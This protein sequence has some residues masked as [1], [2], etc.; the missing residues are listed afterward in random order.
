VLDINRLR[1]FRSVVAAGSIQA[2]ATSLGYTPSAVSQQVAA[3]QRET[4]LELVSRVG[5]GI[6]PT[7]AG[8][9][10]AAAADGV[11]TQLGEVETVVA[12]LRAGRSGALSVSYFASVGAAWMP[13]LV[14]ALVAGFPQLRLD[15]MICEDL[16]PEP[17]ADIQIIVERPGFTPAAGRQARH[18]LED[19]YVAVLPVGHSLVGAGA[20][21]LARLA[22]ERWIDND[23]TDGWCRR[24]LLQTCHAAGFSPV[25]QV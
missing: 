18:L 2:A 12:D 21:E 8:L 20:I 10:L 11:L 17:G 5:R 9:R 23:A 22:G 7:P 13:Q 1:V 24:N 25:F 6:R 4:G 15:L 19:P 16:P 3:L 14:R